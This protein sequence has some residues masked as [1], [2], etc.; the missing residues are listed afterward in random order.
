M[1]CRNHEKCTNYQHFSSHNLQDYLTSDLPSVNIKAPL[2]AYQLQK[3]FLT[4]PSPEW[5]FLSTLDTAYQVKLRLCG[6]DKL[7]M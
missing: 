4:Q 1:D 2:I 7:R 3:Y 6:N 5:I